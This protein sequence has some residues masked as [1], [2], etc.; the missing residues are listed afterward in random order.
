MVVDRQTLVEDAAFHEAGH[1]VIAYEVGWCCR[2]VEI[3][4]VRNGTENYTAVAYRAF[5][6]NLWRKLLGN[7]AGRLA[8]AKY[9]DRVFPYADEG[10]LQ[11]VV[12]TVREDEVF[13][14][15]D[16]E[17]VQ[18]IL[19][20]HLGASDQA[21]MAIFRE[22]ERECWEMLQ[23]EVVWSKVER[24]AAALLEHGRIDRREVERI[25]GVEA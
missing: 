6:R 17:S 7:H 23:D 22:Y 12:E 21:V 20:E 9:L 13:G 5:D 3:E 2:Y 11:F 15:D 4:G 8:G 14:S 10:D 1:A 25:L 18:S 24:L 19:K 16:A